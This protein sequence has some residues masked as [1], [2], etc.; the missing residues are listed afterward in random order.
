MTLNIDEWPC[1]ESHDIT[2]TTMAM[3]G[4]VLAPMTRTTT[5]CDQWSAR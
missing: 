3:S 5:I 2:T 1:T 4:K